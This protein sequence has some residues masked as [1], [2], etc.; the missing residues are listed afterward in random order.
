MSIPTPLWR[1]ILIGRRPGR[2]VLRM[3]FLML[4]AWVMHRYVLMPIRVVGISMSPTFRNGSIKFVLRQAYRHAP[5]ERGDVVAVLDKGRR[6]LL[7]KRVVGLPGE[8]VA[9]HHGLLTINGHPVEE[10]YVRRRGIPWEYAGIT[11]GPTEYFVVGDNRS[12][13]IGGHYLGAT[14]RERII[15]KVWF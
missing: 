13:D 11:L 9:F 15:G 12:M 6:S 1:R 7:L 5:P 3:L 14:E 4:T 2:T 8:M 10:T